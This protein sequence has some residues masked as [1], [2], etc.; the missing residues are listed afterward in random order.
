MLSKGASCTIFFLVFGMTR[1]GIE[2]RSAGPLANTLLIRPMDVNIRYFWWEIVNFYPMSWR[3]RE[4]TALQSFW[5]NLNILSNQIHFGFPQMKKISESISKLTKKKLLA[6]SVLTRCTEIKENQ[7][8]NPHHGVWSGHW[9]WWHWTLILF[10]HGPL[11]QH[12]GLH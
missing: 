5:T 9:R 1:P 12:G 4:K 3:T 7:T 2:L 6:Y 11:T 8:P 10:L